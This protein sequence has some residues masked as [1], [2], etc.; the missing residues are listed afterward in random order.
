MRVGILSIG[1]LPK[2]LLQIAEEY[3]GYNVLAASVESS[4]R[5]A[6]WLNKKPEDLP[7]E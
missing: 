3:A 7:T 1:T 5:D 2:N 4:P 6:D